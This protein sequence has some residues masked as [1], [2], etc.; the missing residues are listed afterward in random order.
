[1]ALSD[2]IERLGRIIFEAPFNGSQFSRDQPEV[3]EIR[4][5]LID[6]VKR[7]S[8][9]AAGR[10]VFPHNLV[11]VHLLGVPE[12]Q[13]AAFNGDFFRNYFEKEL[14]SSLKRS[15]YRFPEDLQLEFRTTPRLPAPKEAWIQV[16]AESRAKPLDPSPIIAHRSARLVV[17][18]GTANRSEILLKRARI[19]IGRTTEV[20]RS[21]GPSRR[22]DL[23]FIEDTEINRTVS[24]E[25]AHV[26]HHKTSGEYRLYNDRWY[27]SEG[28]SKENCGLWII[29]DGLSQEVHRNPRGFK[30]H[31]GDDIQLGQALVRFLLK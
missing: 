11:R 25:H 20:S 16:E 28:R 21:D 6:E 14:K 31:P 17:L 19:N 26:V 12:T 1:M 24:R 2:L 5:A 13:S 23:A 29:R 22:N 9:Q 8:H 15:S 30:L 3:A 7:K 18:R 4:L 10:R 27:K